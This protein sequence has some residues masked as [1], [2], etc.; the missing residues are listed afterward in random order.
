MK[1]LDSGLLFGSH[2]VYAFNP[3]SDL[4]AC[5][6]AKDSHQLNLDWYHGC[7]PFPGFIFSSVFMF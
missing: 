1:I 5:I 6:R 7:R 4:G 2:P 3:G